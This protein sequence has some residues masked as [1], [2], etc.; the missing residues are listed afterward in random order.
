[1]SINIRFPQITGFKAEE[2]LTQIKSYLHQLVE[3]LNWA[4][5]TIESGKTAEESAGKQPAMGS[6]SEET[7]NELKSLLIQSS[8]TLN[9][10]YEKINQ[11]LE[12]YYLK[13]DV[14]NAY[15]E[16]L[17]ERFADLAEVYASQEA[18]EAYKESVVQTFA[19]LAEVYVAQSDLQTYKE[20]VVKD[21]ADLSDIY[22]SKV[23]FLA[24]VQ[25]ME[26]TINGLANQYAAKV[27]FEAY[28]QTNDLAIAG[29]QGEIESL[30]QMIN[31][32]QNT[33]GE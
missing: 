18:F 11:R 16:E 1:M 14:F 4:F 29:M 6:L 31:D 23:T 21:F 17:S 12:G 19:A 26:Q 33:G 22:A 30:Q 8:N 27:D 20:Q 5:L 15:K 13:Q 25:E 32:M 28:K 9:S 24:H 10:Y 2:Q 3:Q 7:F